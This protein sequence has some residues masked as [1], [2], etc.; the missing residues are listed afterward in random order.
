VKVIAVVGVSHHTAPLAVRERLALTAARNR[1]LVAGIVEGGEVAEAVAISTCNRTELYLSADGSDAG[2]LVE[3]G[4]AELRAVAGEQ[5]Q[6]PE[7]VFYRHR[8]ERAVLHLY[9]VAAGLDSL[10]PG[11][12]EIL[13]QVRAALQQARH[14][15]TAGPILSRLFESG[16]DTARRVR[17]VT[18]IGAQAASVGSVAATLARRTLDGLDDATILLIGAGKTSELVAVNLLARGAGRVLVANRT[19]ARAATLADRF[20]GVPVPMDD[21][22]AHLAEADVVICATGAPHTILDA[23]TVGPALAARPDRPL[24]L[25]DLAVPRDVDP[26]VRDLPGCTLHDIDDL[27]RVVRRNRSARADLAP[28]GEEIVADEAARFRRWRDSLDVVPA[29]AGLRALAEQVRSE[30]LAKVESRWEAL[31]PRDRALVDRLTRSIV[32]KLLHEPTVRLRHIGAEADAA[33]LAATV[34]AL[35]DL[36][37]PE[38]PAQQG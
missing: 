16:I 30:E 9:R 11:E 8:G 36:P 28:A 31:T 3:I 33:E 35:F 5:D 24:V 14:E 26:A 4:M 29:I 7:D 17:S 10:V 15:R 21:L 1:C 34:T 32:N 19:L 18:G 12:A 22:P 23:A 38:A 6:L 37:R 20:D 13:G 27:E 2:R 25:I